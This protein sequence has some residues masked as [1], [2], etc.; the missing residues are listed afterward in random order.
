MLYSIGK[1]SSVMLHLARKAFYQVRYRSRYC[2][3][4]PVGN[5]VRCTPFAIGAPPTH[6]AASCWY[7]KNPESGV[8]INRSFTVA[9]D[10]DIMKTEGLS[11]R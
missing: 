5:S 1:D 3:L 4:I 10:T 7:A 11:R 9:P 8:G 2:T 6:M